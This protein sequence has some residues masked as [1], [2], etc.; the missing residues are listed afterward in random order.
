MSTEIGVGGIEVFGAESF[1]TVVTPQSVHVWSLVPEY[2]GLRLLSLGVHRLLIGRR[3]L[4]RIVVIGAVGVGLDILL[5]WLS[6]RSRKGFRVSVM[7]NG[8]AGLDSDML[9]CIEWFGI[10]IAKI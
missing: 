3:T 2:A 8:V 1:A 6:I 7:Q 9:G 4:L 10:T 5:A